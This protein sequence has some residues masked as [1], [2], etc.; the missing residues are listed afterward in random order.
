MHNTLDKT[1]QNGRI[2]ATQR[3]LRRDILSP[4]LQQQRTQWSV[5]DFD[6]ILVITAA[7]RSG[8]SL[9]YDL[10][11]RHSG[12]I[13]T[14]S[15]HGK[16]YTLNDIAYPRFTNDKLTP[17]D[18][19][20]EEEQ[21]VK[22][23][24]VTSAGAVTQ[25]PEKH[26]EFY[27]DRFL[28]HLPMQFYTR[29][30]DYEA[31]REQWLE[32]GEYGDEIQHPGIM[33]R[34]Y[35]QPDVDNEKLRSFNVL[36]NY[37]IAETPFVTPHV[38]KRPLQNGDEEKTLLLKTS[39]DCHRLE[40]LDDML[41][42]DNT[43]YVHLTRN[44]AASINGLY[45]GWQSQR[46]FFTYNTNDDETLHLDEYKHSHLWSY[47]L[48]PGWRDYT[49][50]SLWNVTAA[51]WETANTNILN[52]DID[53]E[54]VKRVKAERIFSASTR[55]QTLDS[56]LS[57][58]SVEEDPGD[59]YVNNLIGPDEVMTTKEPREARWR[60]REEHVIKAVETID[61]SLI[62][63]LDYGDMSKWI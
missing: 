21:A 9:L 30:F 59:A 24:I 49:N 13:S 5:E 23:D 7:S 28:H 50:T 58:A 8:S 27:I 42:H 51:Q 36:H 14:Y 17:G 10:L 52:A 15:E 47:D 6:T 12:I 22:N 34:Y 16:F 39:C 48:F 60:E 44:P 54:R 41:D 2:R 31:M 18:T 35:D 53:E 55:E 62:H 26:R 29:N 46:G 40:W 37:F 1:A 56:I 38:H 61:T 4:T 57:F 63:T 45:D 11:R 25:T 33:R 32:N 43:R 20:V 3:Q 19:G